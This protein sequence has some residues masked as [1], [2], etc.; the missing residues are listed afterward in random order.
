MPTLHKTVEGKGKWL[1]EGRWWEEVG[2]FRRTITKI[3]RVE[4]TRLPLL[5]G[6]A[7]WNVDRRRKTLNKTMVEDDSF[8]G[9]QDHRHTRLLD[10]LL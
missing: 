9:V 3:K 6:R 7:R 8:G 5:E 2:P 4:W 1:K 10:V